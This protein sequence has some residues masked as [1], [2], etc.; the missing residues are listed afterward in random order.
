MFLI[1]FGLFLVAVGLALSLWPARIFETQAR[2]WNREGRLKRLYAAREPARP[3]D[4]WV[5]RGVAA[6]F[7]VFGIWV[8]YAASVG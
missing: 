3:F 1:V 7:M 6:S 2:A 4:V 8:L 5:L